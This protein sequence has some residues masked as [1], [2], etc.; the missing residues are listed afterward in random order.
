MGKHESTMTV[1]VELV[2]AHTVDSRAFWLD[3]VDRTLRTFLQTV[4]LF[5]VGGATVVDISWTSALSSA[6]LAALVSLLLALATSTAITSGNLW[7]DLADRAARTFAATLVGAI[8]ATGTLS[9]VH[10]QE[11]VS[12]ALTAA[13]ISV[14]TSL[15][16]VNVGATKGLPSAAPVL[17]ELLATQIEN[18][19]ADDDHA[20]N[21]GEQG[22]D[23]RPSGDPVA[24]E[25]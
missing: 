19:P 16:T 24:R 17:P 6:A 21:S 1:G 20:G 2:G 3:L 7:I 10:W 22:V 15:T 11:V 18:D 23:G 25:E 8:P 5:L 9:D 12:L 14:L 4:L 13:L